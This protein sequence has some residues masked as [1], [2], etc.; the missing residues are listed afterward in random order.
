M[1]GRVVGNAAKH[2]GEIVLRVDIVQFGGF[3][4]RVNGCGATAAGIGTGKEIVLTADRNRTVILPISGKKL[5]SITAGTR[6]MG[7]GFGDNMSSSVRSVKLFMSR[8]LPA[9]S[10]RSGMDARRRRLRRDGVG[11]AASDDR[12][13]G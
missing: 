2:V 13:P 3:D 8:W 7:G 9:T 4:Q 1:S 5:R 12:G 11:D 10:C 6:C